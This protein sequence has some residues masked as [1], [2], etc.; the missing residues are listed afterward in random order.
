MAKIFRAKFRDLLRKTDYFDQVPSGVWKQAWV[1]DIIPVGSGEAAFKYLAPYVFRVAL[2]NKSI[3]AIEDSK[4]TF[5]YRDSQT[6]TARTMTVT[7]EEFIRRF[8]QHVLPKG[9]QKVRTY[10]LWHP[11]HRHCL[12][13]V[14]EQLQ[15][16]VTA[17]KEL[18][19]PTD[20]STSMTQRPKGFCC[21][22]CHCEMI[23]ICQVP[24]KRG[25]P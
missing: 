13:L 25:P 23:R 1:V 17:R 12:C 15:A 3:V 20:S 18:D 8:L 11:R 19:E 22:Q 14:K 24:R 2:S 4:I 7:A 16:S 9:F 10:G 21:P 5:R 6:N